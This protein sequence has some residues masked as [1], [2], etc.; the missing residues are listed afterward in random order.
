MSAPAFPHRLSAPLVLP[1]N[2]FKYEI[3][4][5][6][7]AAFKIIR[8]ES[9]GNSIANNLVAGDVGQRPFQPVARLDSHTMIV[10]ESE[11][12][13]AIVSSPLPDLPFLR[14]AMGKVIDRTL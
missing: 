12:D 2:R 3:D 6:S 4:S 7:E 9:R 13:D 11:K 5:S 1:A 8:A 14:S 10:H